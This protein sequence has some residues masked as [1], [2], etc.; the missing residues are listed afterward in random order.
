MKIKLERS[1]KVYAYHVKATIAYA[2]ERKDLLPFLLRVRETR[3]A[4][5]KDVSEHLFG[6][7]RTAVAKRLLNICTLYGLLSE[8]KGRYL[9]TEAGIKAIEEKQIFVPESGTWTFWIS[10]A[11]LLP[12]P[13][14][15]IK[16]WKEPTAYDEVKGKKDKKEDRKFENLPKYLTAFTGKVFKAIAGKGETCRIDEFEGEKKGEIIFPD[17]E[18][19]LRWFVEKERSRLHL[20][21]TIEKEKVSTDLEAPQLKFDQIWHDLLESEKVWK[22]WDHNVLRVTFDE[23]K[24]NERGS[25]KRTLKINS[26]KISDFGS[27]N[28]TE[29]QSVPLAASNHEESEKWAHW[30][31]VQNVT[32]YATSENFEIWHQEAVKPFSEFS[33]RLPNRGDLAIQIRN[34]LSDGKRLKPEYWHLQAAED[35]NL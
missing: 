23:T 31:L 25:M 14:L 13:V 9:L 15:G 29:I 20:D 1:V 6:G 27:F 26:P 32:D 16:P 18:L 2:K 3:D 34:G 28:A 5:A 33:P 11:P 19:M 22:R 8:E 12:N 17:V 4:D 21:G 30:R 7:G 35:W 10:N 24:E